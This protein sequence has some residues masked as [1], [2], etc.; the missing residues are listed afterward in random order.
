MANTTAIE[1]AANDLPDFE[2][3]VRT[4]QRMVFS[5][6]YH[7]L[8]DHALAE[9]VSQDVFLRL[10]RSLSSMQSQAHVSAWLCKV[11]TH[12]CIDYAR[13]RRQDVALDEI[14]EPS[15]ESLPGDPLMSRRLQ[16]M[17]ASLPPKARAVVILHYQEDLDPEEIARVL[18]WRL[19]TVKSQL[20]RSLMMLRSKFGRSFGE[21]ES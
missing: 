8:H 13:R 17:V 6:S 20:Q 12:R 10:F 15:S 2:E 16:K 19:N 18:G 3:L 7:F 14:P 21:V 11:T 1:I 4:H 9:E 5:I